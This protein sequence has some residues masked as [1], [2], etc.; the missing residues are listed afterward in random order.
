M[1]EI[2]FKDGDKLEKLR[3][4]ASK[5]VSPSRSSVLTAGTAFTVPEYEMGS[6]R[7]H[8]Y[9]DGILC[10]EGTANQYTEV[11][12]TTIKFNDNIPSDMEIVVISN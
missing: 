8:V 5:L 9:L 12:T 11:T 3:L 1:T 6:G 10:L 4:G 7:L 2:Y